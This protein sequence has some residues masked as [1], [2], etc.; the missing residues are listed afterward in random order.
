M[1][2]LLLTCL[3]FFNAIADKDFKEAMKNYRTGNY[4]QALDLFKKSEEPKSL[5]YIGAMYEKGFYV[6]K[7][8]NKALVYYK[9]SANKY[10]LKTSRHNYAHI[11]FE[12]K[13]YDK[14]LEQFELNK[15]FMMSQ[16]FIGKIYYYGLGVKEDED[17]GLKYLKMAADKGYDYAQLE[18]VNIYFNAGYLMANAPEIA[19][20]YAQKIVKKENNNKRNFALAYLVYGLKMAS[21]N[22]FEEALPKIISAANAG[23]RGAYMALFHPAYIS[24]ALHYE[25]ELIK[26]AD[27]NVF[28]AIYLLSLNYLKISNECDS[29]TKLLKGKNLVELASD[30]DQIIKIAKNIE[31][32]YIKKCGK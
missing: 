5:F 20:K 17:K 12:Q 9:E 8:I 23:Y 29:A 26:L 2:L 30:N 18:L 11:L 21:D 6:K 14:A 22:N 3:M 27:E 24:L 25:P 28:S 31:S 7:D 16:Y 19:F 15:D 10:G 4:K 1:K 32:L 13:K